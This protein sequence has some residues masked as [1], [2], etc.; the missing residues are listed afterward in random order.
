MRATFFVW[1]LVSKNRLLINLIKKLISP[2]WTHKYRKDREVQIERFLEYCSIKEV[3]REPPSIAQVAIITDKL[4]KKQMLRGATDFFA[5]I[6]VQVKPIK[7]LGD[8]RFLTHQ[9]LVVDLTAKENGEFV[10]R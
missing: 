8:E 6:G 7:R 9:H 4:T 5:H 3:E 10:I 1:G 2:I